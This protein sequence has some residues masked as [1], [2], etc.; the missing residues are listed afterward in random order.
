LELDDVGEGRARHLLSS[1]PSLIGMMQDIVTRSRD[2]GYAFL[3]ISSLEE[4]SKLDA[5]SHGGLVEIV[6]RDVSFDNVN[7]RLKRGEFV[8]RPTRA[9]LGALVGAHGEDPD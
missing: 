8:C 3:D 6:E 1:D 9:G 2:R 5:L 4:Y 7:M